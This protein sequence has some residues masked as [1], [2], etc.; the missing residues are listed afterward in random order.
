M[1]YKPRT[2]LDVITNYVIKLHGE[3]VEVLN[4][5]EEKNSYIW[6]KNKVLFE[7]QKNFK[8]FRN[9][10]EEIL[11]LIKEMDDEIERSWKENPS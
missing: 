1:I 7:R 5:T 2:Y 4:E 11:T 10:L 9:M 3:V 8:E 6:G